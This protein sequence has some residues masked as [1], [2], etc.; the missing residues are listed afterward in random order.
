M[1]DIACNRSGDTFATVSDD[2]TVRLWKKNPSG[3]SDEAGYKCIKTA[4][5]HTARVWKAFLAENKGTFSGGLILSGAEDS[6]VR[7]W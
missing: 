6:E 2:R 1:F 5:G 7:V 3:G 4:Y